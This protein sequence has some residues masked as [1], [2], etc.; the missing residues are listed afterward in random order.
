MDTTIEKERLATVETQVKN[1]S[2]ELSGIWKVLNQIQDSL[3]KSYKTDW[4]TIFAGLVVVGALFGFVW[5]AAI[6]PINLDVERTS[7][8][9]ATLAQAVVTQDEKFNEEKYSRLKEQDDMDK[10]IAI[11][12][13][14]LKEK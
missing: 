14:Q 11:I 13:F 5:G 9:S 1:I 12:E 8:S 6:H 7:Q 3:N 10:R 2:T 4:Q